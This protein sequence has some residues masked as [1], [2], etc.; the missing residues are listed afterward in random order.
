MEIQ[1]VMRTARSVTVTLDDGGT[2]ETKESYRL[3]LNDEEQKETD[4]VVTSLYDLEPNTAY[5]LVVKK[6]S[7]DIE[8]HLSF[9]TEEESV[10]INVK[11][12][13]AAGDGKTDDTG[14][15]QAAVMACPPAYQKSQRGLICQ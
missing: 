8:G 7:G 6:K 9:Q 1:L 14:F 5:T 10:T 12:L 11:D 3:F 13:G 15:I 4:T 2:Y